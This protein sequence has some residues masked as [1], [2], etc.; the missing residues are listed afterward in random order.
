MIFLRDLGSR[1]KKPYI[2]LAWFINLLLA[3]PIYSITIATFAE[4]VA[5]KNLL[6]NFFYVWDF[7][8]AGYNR[9][10][11]LASSVSIGT[12]FLFTLLYAWLRYRNDRVIERHY[13]RSLM[14]GAILSFVNLFPT[15]LLYQISLGESNLS[16]LLLVTFLGPILALGLVGPSA[17]FAGAVLGIINGVIAHIIHIVIARKT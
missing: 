12:A 10:F 4:A 16:S 5:Q 2:Y 17:L 15:F 14:G 7:F 13:L 1:L 8:V 11:Y 3:W 9:N 6:D